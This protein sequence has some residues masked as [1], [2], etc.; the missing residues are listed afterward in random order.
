MVSGAYRVDNFLQILYSWG[1][2]DYVLPF[3]LVFTL[4]YA[5]LHKTKILGDKKSFDVVIALVLGIFFIVPHMGVGG[6]RYPS[7]LDPVQMLLQVL[8]QVS[9]VLIAVLALLILVG[10]W[11][12]QSQWVAGNRVTGW[13]V[14]LSAIAVLLIFGSSVGWWNGWNWLSGLFGDETVAIFIMIVVFGL[15]I[16]FVTADDSGTPAE[17]FMNNLGGLF[18]KP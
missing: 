8:P 15:I 3:I 9:L 7:G 2:I 10:I 17:S 13:I 6:I 12:A 18:K 1:F 14:L 5:I 4:V 16:K 11:G